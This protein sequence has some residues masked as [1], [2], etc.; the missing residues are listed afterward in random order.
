MENAFLVVDSDN[1][2]EQNIF[3]IGDVC[4]YQNKTRRIAPGLKEADKV[5]D[6]ITC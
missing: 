5:F 3:A 2:V 4:Q 1:K 6:L